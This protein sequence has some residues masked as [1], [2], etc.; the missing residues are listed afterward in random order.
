ME[1]KKGLL[2]GMVLLMIS[3]LIAPGIQSQAAA[4]SSVKKPYVIF[5]NPL[6][7]NPVFTDEENGMKQAAKESGFKLKIIGPS[8]ID[9]GQM[10][11]ALESAIA[12]KPDAIIT[13]P[14]N[15]SA[16]SNTYI[17]AKRAGIPIIN[18]SSDSPED[19]RVCFIGTNNT[20]YGIQAADYI[21]KK[22]GGKANVCIMMV[23]LDVSNQLEQKKAFETRAAQKY[24]NIK[25]VITEQDN[26]DSMTAV[27]K[28]QDIFKAHPEVNTVLCLN[29]TCGNSAALVASENN[30]T[31]KMTILAIDAISE[32]VD[33]IS[34]GK[35]WA[36]MAQKFWRMGYLGGK[37]AMDTIKGKKVPSFTDS[38]TILVTKDNL[39]TFQSEMHQP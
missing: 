36:T 15:Y 9:D 25:I 38:G 24:P 17:K 34:K 32:T 37:Y 21:A 7:G 1:M 27:Q 29:S 30:L 10:V 13:V 5:V 20:N 39:K 6:V 19:S 35:I 18:T 14:Y 4:G 26:G 8:V 31:N 33:N 11:Q 28:F 3:V 2:W 12:E 22:T 23:R 16:L